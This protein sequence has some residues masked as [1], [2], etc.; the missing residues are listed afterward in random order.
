MFAGPDASETDPVPLP[1][2]LQL[3]PFDA[4]FHADPYAVYRTLREAAPLHRETTSFYPGD[5]WTVT[6]H[7]LVE[8]LLKDPRLSVDARR[9]GMPRDGRADNAVTRAAPDM[10]NLDDPEHARLRAALGRAFTPSSVERFGPRIAEIFDGCVADQPARFDVV[11]AIAK[12]LPTIVIAEYLGIDASRH[13]DFKHWTDELLLQGYPMPSAEQWDRIVAADASLRAYAQELI[14]SRRAAPRDDLVSRMIQDGSLDEEELVSM[15]FLLIG[16]GNFTTTDLIAN[17]LL[18]LLQHGAGA[19]DDAGAAVEEVLRF[20]SPSLS[21]RRFVTEDVEVGEQ[22]IRAGS[23]VNLV[24]AAANHDP[25]LTDDAD[26]F[27]TDRGRCPHLAFGRGIHHCLGAPLAR[28]EARVVVERFF[29]RFP[30]ARLVS[31]RRTRMMAFRGCRELI[32]ET[33]PA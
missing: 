4:D 11:A 21:L 7:V 27:R 5:T 10:M 30:A 24:L 14:A 17:T 12:P 20:D 18:A 23:V 26:R 32:V 13:A 25:A 1:E 2:G 28:L 16:A 22:T 15:C 19:P 3:T 33:G 9:I 29:E 6:S 8:P 31:H